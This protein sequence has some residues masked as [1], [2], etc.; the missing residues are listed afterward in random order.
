MQLK[1]R[2]LA[3]ALG[4]AL[5]PFSALA[6][7]VELVTE[8]GVTFQLTFGTSITT[9]NGQT[10]T[11]RVDTTRAYSSA[12]PHND[13]IR[14]LRNILLAIPTTNDITGWRLAAVRPLSAD[15]LEIDTSFYLYLVNDSQNIRLLVP[16]DRFLIAANATVINSVVT[17]STRNI[18]TG[19][20]SFVQ[21]TEMSF[22]PGFVRKEVPA[23]ITGPF[24]ENVNG[25]N[26]T[27]N[28]STKTE[29]AFTL[30]YLSTSGFSTVAFQTRSP[31]PVFSFAYD[32]VRFS[33]RGDFTGV[34]YNTVTATKKYTTRGIPDVV[35][36]QTVDQ[37][38]TPSF[39]LVNVQVNTIAAK[40]VDRA[41][42]PAVSF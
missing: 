41:L 2:F 42:Y 30:D 34:F 6:Q 16:P 7:D 13:V 32:S 4:L 27:Y 29:A 10:G 17:H 11:A 26:R 33:G 39:G 22:T 18:I 37:N 25:Q 28:I 5:A 35:L 19:K 15:L 14:S 3:L 8:A 40:L 12:L 23:V 9:T 36:S 38:P 20:G 24:T 21:N 31:E 1:P